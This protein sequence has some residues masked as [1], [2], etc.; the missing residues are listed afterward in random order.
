MARG[1]AGVNSF[2]FLYNLAT[3][4][5]VSFEGIDAT[6]NSQLELVRSDLA[7][8]YDPDDGEVYGFSPAGSR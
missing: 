8:G 1:R 3:G 5:A 6:D 7:L 2:H 4:E